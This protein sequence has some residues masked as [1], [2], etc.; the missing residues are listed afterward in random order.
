MDVTVLEAQVYPGGCASTFFH[1]G[2]RFDA[3]ATLA[4]GF[5]P[6]GP[7]DLLSKAVGISSWDIEYDFPAMVVH[8]PSGDS[9]S[10][11]NRDDRW[12]EYK[13]SFGQDSLKF[14][15]WQERTANLLWQFALR[16]PAWPIRSIDDLKSSLLAL[17][18]N[19]MKNSPQLALEMFRSVG[20][21]LPGLNENLSLF[22]D[23]QLLISAQT[24]NQYANALYSASALDL[25]RRGVAH[26]SKGIGSLADALVQSI[27]NHGGKVIFRQKVTSI[28]QVGAKKSRVRTKKKE[29]LE[30]DIVIANLTPW[31]LYQLLDDQ[32]QSTFRKLPNFSTDNWGAFMLYLG[33]ESKAIP[34]DFPLHHQIIKQVPLGEGNSVFISISP[35]WDDTRAPSGYRALTISSH[36]RLG[37]WWAPIDDNFATYEAQKNEMTEKV[38]SSVEKVLPDIRRSIRLLL[39]GTPVTFHRYTGRKLGWVGGF[40]QTSLFKTYHPKLAKNLWLV[41]DSI[42]PGQSTAAVALGGL[43]VAKGILGHF[44]VN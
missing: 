9:I 21:H 24:T 37:Q 42:F 23:G 22:V 19:L 31:N 41:G 11:H 44:D 36:T 40:Q 17:D 38:L 32:S 5:Y 30:A 33:I 12:I 16:L 35:A 15:H 34:Q 20:H 27:R 2:Y 18:V 8:L 7:M 3:G 25:P 39:P 6:G 4:A 1:K 28:S 26:F 10:C 43:R 14:F 13:Y 29:E